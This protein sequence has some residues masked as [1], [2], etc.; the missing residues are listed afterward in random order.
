MS[1][2]KTY[3]DNVFAAFPQTEHVQAL[4]R[5]MLA[6][7]EEKYASLRQQGHSEHEAVGIVIANFG[8]IHEIAAEMGMASPGQARNDDG[9]EEVISL[10]LYEARNYVALASKYMAFVGAAFVLII[11]GMSLSFL[12]SQNLGYTF[13]IYAIAL[14][15]TA[16]TVIKL[17]QRFAAFQKANIHLDADAFDEMA[18]QYSRFA[19]RALVITGVIVGIV[20]LLLAMAGYDR[21]NTPLLAVTACVGAFIFPILVGAKYAYDY[22]LGRWIYAS[23]RWTYMWKPL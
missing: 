11:I 16:A 21:S 2:I 18:W 22:M 3:L 12:S 9:G 20:V 17:N 1:T 15:I 19:R 7:M 4:K 14:V 5:D 23:G 8:S 10:S 13:A 6:D